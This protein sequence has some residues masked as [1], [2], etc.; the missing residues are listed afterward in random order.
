MNMLNLRPILIL[1]C[2]LFTHT[3]L[4]ADSQT[5]E[6]LT[7]IKT[8]KLQLYN[9]LDSGSIDSAVF[10]DQTEEDIAKMQMAIANYYLSQNDRKNAIISAIIAR[11]IMQRL[12][13]NDNDPRLIPIYSLLV[14]AYAANVDVD[15]P[16]AD[17]ADATKSKMYREMIDH[18]HAE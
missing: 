15:D 13:N 12:Y 1:L 9:A 3:L 10:D 8:L 18:I 2:C 16:K 14:Q 17:S 5:Q 11:K 4:Y 6:Q 7:Q